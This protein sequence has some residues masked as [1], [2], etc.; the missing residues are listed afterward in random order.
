MNLRSRVLVAAAVLA[1]TSGMAVAGAVTAHAAA[2]LVSA[3]T[4]ITN[5]PDSGGNGV[6]ADDNFTRTLTISTDATSSDCA[7]LTG[8]TAAADAC[9]TASISDSGNATTVVGAFQP[10]QGSTTAAN[11][12]GDKITGPA[13]AV[14][15]T[16]TA[17]YQFYAPTGDVPSA[18]NVPATVNDNFT[19]QTG[20]AST[21]QWYLQA[22]TAAGR[23]NVNTNGLGNWSWKYAN[24]CESWTDANTNSD[25][26][27]TPLADDGNITGKVCPAPTTTPPAT[28]GD[29]VNGYGNGLDV[30]RQH[31]AFNGIIAGWPA[32][33]HDPATQFQ[34]LNEGTWH[35][36]AVFA[37]EAGS[38]GWCVSDP[39]GGALPA[40]ADP[41][42]LVLRAC[43]ASLFQLFYL[44]G[45]YLV[46][47]VFAA[48]FGTGGY[49]NP[50]GTGA[51]LAV[52]VSPVAWGGSKYAW[53]NAASLPA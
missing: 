8:F 49:V 5:N 36:H 48:H 46:S 26:Q 40:G 2:P 9:Y 39:M 51:Q 16:G 19:A 3:S 15:F 22:F 1:L 17:S 30:F 4:T 25:G 21:S 34:Q 12:T 10:N 43:N 31:F 52:G 29:Y 37:L 47:A 23:A 38:T 42:G 50:D 13:E 6:W 20:A 33:Q 11:Q 18:A 28:F 44:N 35:G 32:T 45:R 53:E 24:S 41:Y 27:S 7:A 14:P